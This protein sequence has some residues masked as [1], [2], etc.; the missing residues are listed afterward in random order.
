MGYM[1][2]RMNEKIKPVCTYL[3]QWNM[4]AGGS[5]SS[6]ATVLGTRRNHTFICT[7]YW[8]WSHEQCTRFRK[9]SFFNLKQLRIF[10]YK[11]YTNYE[12]HKE[13]T[14]S[15]GSS[16]STV[17]RLWTGRPRTCGSIPERGKTFSSFPKRLD[18]LWGPTTHLF[19][20]Y[21]RF[22]WVKRP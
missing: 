6:S 8:L 7:H 2:Q 10:V 18:R 19:G 15:C 14:R 17:T 12:G 16:V 22:W 1:T 3:W 9:Y 5:G 13:I 4:K 20:G 11:Q 21:R